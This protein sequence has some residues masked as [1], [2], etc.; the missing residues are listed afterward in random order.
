MSAA[1][2]LE[3][4]EEEHASKHIAAKPDMA[5]SI[6][7]LPLSMLAALAASILHPFQHTCCVSLFSGMDVFLLAPGSSCAIIWQ[8]VSCS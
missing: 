5:G 2:V 4:L 8:R 7:S 3:W 6:Q 1:Y